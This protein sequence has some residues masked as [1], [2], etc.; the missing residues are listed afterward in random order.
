MYRSFSPRLVLVK[1]TEYCELYERQPIRRLL[2]FM[3][4]SAIPLVAYI[5]AA[6]HAEV[7][8]FAVTFRGLLASHAVP[9]V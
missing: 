7:S 8:T 4:G 1:R 9:V 5:L 3:T 2:I 6:R